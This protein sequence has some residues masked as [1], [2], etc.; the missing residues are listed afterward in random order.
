[1]NVKINGY[2]FIPALK[3]FIEIIRSNNVFTADQSN[4]E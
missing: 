1:M 3:L 2:H 4:L